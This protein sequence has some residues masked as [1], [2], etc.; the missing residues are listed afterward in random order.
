MRTLLTERPGHGTELAAAG[1]D[2]L[3]VFS[4]DGGFNEV[5][6]GAP[7]G[8]PLGFLPGGGANVLSRALGLPRD[9]AAA[10]QAGRRGAGV[11]GARG[12]SPSGA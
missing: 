11:A 3:V 5:L 7:P 1:G 12:R 2:A 8:V 10:A 4:G 6:N 9:P